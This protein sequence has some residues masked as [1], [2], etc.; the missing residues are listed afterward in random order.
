MKITKEDFAKLK[1]F[2]DPVLE[3]VPVAEYRKENPTFSAKRVRWGY[4]HAAGQPA[5]EFLC[6][7]LYSYMN[8]D[9][10]DTALKTIVGV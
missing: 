6:G 10:M 9:H 4:F 8:D 3:R 5:L 2:I 1:S 7:H